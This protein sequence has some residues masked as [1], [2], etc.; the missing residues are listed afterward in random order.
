MAHAAKCQGPRMTDTD[1]PDGFERHFRQSPRQRELPTLPHLLRSEPRLR[2]RQKRKLT[3][4]WLPPLDRRENS[5]DRH[6]FRDYLEIG[7]AQAA[8]EPGTGCAW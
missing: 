6:A 3:S 4:S 1:I 8:C 2:S 7:K 5:Q